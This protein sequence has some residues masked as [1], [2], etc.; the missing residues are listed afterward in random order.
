MS[1][2]LIINCDK[3][4]VLQ[5]PKLKYC[6]LSNALGNDGFSFVKDIAN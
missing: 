1:S 2:Y 3:Y 6:I 5:I 4:P